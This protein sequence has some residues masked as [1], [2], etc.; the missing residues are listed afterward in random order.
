[1]KFK[2]WGLLLAAGVV[3]LGGCEKIEPAKI[4]NLNNGKILVIGHGGSGFQSYF[5]PLPANS[6]LGVSKAIEGLHADGVEVDVQLTADK[7][8]ILY[9]DEF[10]QTQTNCSDCIAGQTAEEV[11][12]CRYNLDASNTLRKQ[13]PLITLETVLQKFAGYPKKPQIFIDTKLLNGCNPDKV[14]PL[15]DFAQALATVIAKYNAHAWTHVESSSVLLLQALQ[16]QDSR[17]WLSFYTR[18]PAADIEVAAQLGVAGITVFSNEIT[19]TQVQAAHRQGL[20]VTILGVK[21]R[22]GLVNAIQKNPDAIQTDNIP[23][24][25]NI[26]HD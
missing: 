5:N 11:L 16:A 19:S 13:E 8:L 6:L 26:L 18:N 9:H 21:S 1:M 4:Q 15:T 20:F 22:N 10:L 17:L 24:L 12:K 2:Q 25:I 23:L 3:L 14:P 7:Q